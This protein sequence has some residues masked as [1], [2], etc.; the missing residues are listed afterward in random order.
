MRC[1]RAR[2]EKRHADA[3]DQLIFGALATNGN[4][5][6]FIEGDITMPAS[7]EVQDEEG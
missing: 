6:D 4:Y 5:G 3:V 1:F 2:C 7:P